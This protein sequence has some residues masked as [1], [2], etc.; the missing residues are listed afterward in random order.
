MSYDP[1]I[2][3]WTSEDPIAFEGGDANLDRYVGNAPTNFIDPSGLRKWWG[4]VGEALRGTWEVGLFDAWNAGYG[5]I[6]DDAFEFQNQCYPPPNQGEPDNYTDWQ[7][8]AARHG[9]WQAMLT[10]LHGEGKAKAIGNA[11]EYGTEEYLDTWIDQYNNE[12]AR[13]MGKAA[14][15]FEKWKSENFG[16]DFSWGCVENDIK[17]RV[18]IGLDKGTFITDPNDPR[19]PPNLR[20]T[21]GGGNNYDPSQYDRRYNDGKY[22]YQNERPR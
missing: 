20:P 5:Y 14:Y 13:K 11:H 10:A 22:D 6:G 4:K 17:L 16:R 21:P 7:R 15:H 19:I 18:R 2:G 3:R 1:T 8:N 12:Q 9:Y